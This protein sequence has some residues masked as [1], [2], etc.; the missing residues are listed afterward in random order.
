MWHCITNPQ[1]PSSPNPPTRYDEALTYCL[2]ELG[3]TQFFFPRVGGDWDSNLYFLWHS[4]TVKKQKWL[5]VQ[6]FDDELSLTPKFKQAFGNYVRQMTAHL[7]SK[8]WLDKVVLTTMD[9]PHSQDDLKAVHAFASFVKNIVP[10]VRIF[11]TTAP[12]PELYGVIDVWCAQ[13]Y[14]AV[15]AKARQQQGEEFMFYKNWMNLIDMPMVNP[16]LN[17]WIA[18]RDGAVSWLTYSAMINEWHSWER[19]YTV[20]YPT[21]GIIAWGLGLMWYPGLM[22]SE[23]LKS[24][25]W[26]MMRE[27]AEDYEYLTLLAKRLNELP[28]NLQNLPKVAQA[29]SFLAAVTN[30]ILLSP[31][32]SADPKERTKRGSWK[33]KPNFTTSNR[34]VW[35]RRNETAKWIQAI[36]TSSK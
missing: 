3:M 7:K 14:D 4:P 12:R 9:E 20:Y 16:R 33:K 21:T 24:V 2:D 17:G 35:E 10:E 1:T 29:R 23:I 28:K 36:R 15:E 30:D 8:G 26:E 19:P 27:G 22:Q 31:Q 25:R 18:W 6:I 32:F 34:T 11:C 5:G 13:H